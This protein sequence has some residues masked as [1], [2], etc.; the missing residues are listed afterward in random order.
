V[1][2][3]TGIITTLAGTGS[4][5]SG[6]VFSS[7]GYAMMGYL[8]AFVSL[9]LVGLSRSVTRPAAGQARPGAW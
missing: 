1:I 2:K 7:L 3:A 6:L 5:L 4:A 9:I 8:S